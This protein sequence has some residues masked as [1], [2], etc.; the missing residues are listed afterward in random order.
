ME[1]ISLGR[2]GIK[3]SIIGLGA[4]QAGGKAWGADVEDENILK[5]IKRAYELGINFIDTAEAYGNGHSEEVVGEAIKEI[6]RENLV[7]ATKVHGAHLRYNE[8][9]KA[10]E[11]S[12]RRLG[13]KEIDLYQVHWPDPWEQ[14]PLKHTMKA[15]DQLYKEGKIRAIGVSNFAVR[16][17][18]EARKYLSAT[19]IVSNQVRYNMLQREIEEEVLPY[20]K[21]E[22]ITVI[23]WSPIAQGALTG[24]YDINNKPFDDVRRGNKLFSDHNLKEISRLIPVLGRI[25]RTRNKTITQVALN[26]LLREGNVVPIPGAKNPK[27]AEENA[28]AAGWRLDDQELKE[29]EEVLKGISL[30]Y[31]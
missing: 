15:M 4:W 9:L 1:Y 17:L 7:I 16:D 14:I 12:L 30:D 24:K 26:W 3:V 31:F 18:E 25:A 29:I 28:G 19:D 23:A 13:V 20:C 8:L 22:N 21:K 6:G 11:H 10:A 27:Q 5:A 2:S